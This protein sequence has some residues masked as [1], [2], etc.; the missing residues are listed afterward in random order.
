MRI[1]SE[2]E[3]VSVNFRDKFAGWGGYGLSVGFKNKFD[4]R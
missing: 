1:L 4:K 2:I 3:I